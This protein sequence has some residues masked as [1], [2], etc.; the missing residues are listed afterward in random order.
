MDQP[1][2]EKWIPWCEVVEMTGMDDAGASI[3]LQQKKLPKG[4]WVKVFEGGKWQWKM[5]WP[6]LQ[7]DFN[8]RQWRIAQAGESV[9]PA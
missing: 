9:P 4:Q 3:M 1:E 8:V 2:E 7:V 5:R 6:R